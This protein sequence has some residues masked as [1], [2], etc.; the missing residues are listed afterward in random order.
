MEG[1]ADFLA[2]ILFVL[3]KAMLFIGFL[4][5]LFIGGLY[6]VYRY[7]ERPSQLRETSQVSAPS[8]DNSETV[9]SPTA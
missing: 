7:R 5:A 6:V 4:I 8:D 1:I 3:F 9:E 2:P